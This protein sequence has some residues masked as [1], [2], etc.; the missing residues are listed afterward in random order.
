VTRVLT[1][2][3]TM[4]VRRFPEGRPYTTMS[5][6]ANLRD[7]GLSVPGRPDATGI[8]RSVHFTEE[9]NLAAQRACE[10][11]GHRIVGDHGIVLFPPS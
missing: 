7:H 4:A 3:D 2:A 9:G 11:I 5:L 1:V 8:R 6:R 10:A